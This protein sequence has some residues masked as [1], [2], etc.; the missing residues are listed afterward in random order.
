MSVRR[1]SLPLA[2]PGLNNE[3]HSMMTMIRSLI[4]SLALIWVFFSNPSQ[5]DTY[6]YPQLVKRMTDLPALA[7]LPPPG[8]KT[9][10][11]S[12]YDRAS[13]YDAATDKYI[14]WGANADG[15]GIIRQEGDESVFM[16]V[17]GPG[18]IWRTWAA[19]ARTGHVKIYLDGSPVML[20]SLL[21]TV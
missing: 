6:T 9:A 18:C 4:L 11:A 12:S 14:K 17:Q 21:R 8:E 3:E 5:A 15:Q 19:T 2:I 1:L 20:T 16:D 10:L 7:Q 13:Q